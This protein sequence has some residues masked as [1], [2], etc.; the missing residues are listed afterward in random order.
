MHVRLRNGLNETAH[1]GHAYRQ[2]P[3]VCERYNIHSVLRVQDGVSTRKSRD[4]YSYIRLRFPTTAANHTRPHGTREA[5]AYRPIDAC[6][7]FRNASSSDPWHLDTKAFETDAKSSEN[8]SA[9]TRD[10][11]NNNRSHAFRGLVSGQV[12]CTLWFLRDGMTCLATDRNH[13]TTHSVYFKIFSPGDTST[14][15]ST[16][17][18]KINS[19]R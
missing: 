3:T 6:R 18:G 16:S 9:R 11:V 19:C 17:S 5:H 12:A 10:K 13:D 8:R 1:F 4:L 14:E 7:T 2:P 15:S